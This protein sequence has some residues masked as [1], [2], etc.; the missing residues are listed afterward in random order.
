[1]PRRTLLTLVLCGLLTPLSAVYACVGPLDLLVPGLPSPTDVVKLFDVLTRKDSTTSM[2][3]KLGRTTGQG[4]LLVARMRVDVALERSSRNW[5]GQVVVQM[6]VPSDISYSV[7]LAKIRPE[8]VR[9][10]GEKRQLV[11]AMPPPE[12]E[13]V[14]P[15]LDA[16]RIEN[17]FRRARFKRFDGDTSRHLQNVMLREDYQARA[18]KSA[19][20]RLPQVRE[21]GK[22]ALQALLQ[23]LIG[24]SFPGITVVV[25]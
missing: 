14:T 8:H 2:D 11:V 1:M 12:V 17:T 19:G 15:L 6:T 13:D 16:V 7:D 3:V 4:K 5:R 22:A 18:R 25:E 9:L 21:Q 20:E 24:G 10:D 23:K